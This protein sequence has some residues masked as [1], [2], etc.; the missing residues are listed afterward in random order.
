MASPS[1]EAEDEYL[2]ISRWRETERAHMISAIHEMIEEAR[3]K[4]KSRRAPANERIRWTRLAGQLI[5]YKDSILRSMTQ[6]AM[7]R[8]LIVLKKQVLKNK[9]EE[10]P[11]PGYMFFGQP[12]PKQEPANK[13]E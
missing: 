7:E 9:S 10:K 2:T 3:K 4:A 8:E 13:K 6:E 1:P 5:W 12:P 11:P